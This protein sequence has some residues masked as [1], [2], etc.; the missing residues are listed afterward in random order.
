M[1]SKA[2]GVVAGPVIG[3]ALERIVPDADAD[4]VAS[5]ARG[6]ESDIGARMTLALGD[7]ADTARETPAVEGVIRDERSYEEIRAID[8]GEEFVAEFEA[9]LDEFGHRAASEFDPSRPRWRDAPG[10]VLGIV[11]GNLIADGKEAHRDRLEDANGK[12]KPRSTSC[13]RTRGPVPSAP[14]GDGSSTASCS[15][16]GRTSTSAT[17]RNTRPLTS[18]QHGT[19][20]SS[21]RATT[22][23]AKMC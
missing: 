6:V 12:L 15:R 2:M 21:E 13:G 10:E 23:R 16:T 11:R 14:L 17:S 8:G 9:F 1:E 5:A 18:S 3:R 20:P 22:S 4:L 7:L 19:K